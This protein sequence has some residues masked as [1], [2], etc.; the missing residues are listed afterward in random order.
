MFYYKMQ[1]ES[2]FLIAIVLLALL[3][4]VNSLQ[5]HLKMKKAQRMEPYDSTILTQHIETRPPTIPPFTMN[6][7]TIRPPSITPRPTSRVYGQ[8]SGNT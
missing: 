6:R 2:Y 5:L 8:L 1:S 7:I 4:L 3:L